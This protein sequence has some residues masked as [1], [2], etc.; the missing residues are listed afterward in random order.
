[1]AVFSF[2][3]V[4]QRINLDGL[5]ERDELE[6]LVAWLR[7]SV[8]SGFDGAAIDVGANIGNHSLFFSD[9]FTRVVSFEPHPRT[10]ALLSINAGLVRN[11]VCHNVALSDVT[12]SAVLY[13]D[14]ENMG[15]SGL[16]RKTDRR[17]IPVSVLTLDG[18][19]DLPRP[20]SLIK[21]DV[22]GHEK[23]AIRGSRKI[24]MADRPVVLFEQHAEDFVGGTTEVLELLRTFGY[25]RFACIESSPEIHRSGVMATITSRV[26]QGLAGETISVIE[27]SEFS[28]RSYSFI[29]ALPDGA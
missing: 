25:R 3:G 20:V 17:G 6:E 4:S 27:R 2:D 13:D 26:L 24:L 9:F 12:G 16:S 22:E 5:Y 18:Y 11:V 14:P 28:P 8:P 10:F 21:Y 7:E 1:M 15:S 29:V 23:Q 19:S